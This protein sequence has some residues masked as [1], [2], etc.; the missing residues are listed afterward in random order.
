MSNKLKTE[1]INKKHYYKADDLFDIN[2][3]YFYGCRNNPRN[4]VDKKNIPEGSYLYAYT[5]ND[6]YV[7]S[8]KGYMRAKLYIDKIWAD[9][10]IKGIVS[11]PVDNI[12]DP[13]KLPLV[14]DCNGIEMA[15]PEIKL[16]DDEHFL[17]TD[18][19]KLNIKIRGN[20]DKREYYFFVN[21]ISKHFNLPNLNITLTKKDSGYEK[22]TH[23]KTFAC[24]R[25]DKETKKNNSLY[26]T[27]KG[28]IRCLYVSR[29]PNADKFQ[30]WSTNILLTHQFGSKN[31]KISL[32]SSLMG[33]PT[34]ILKNVLKSCMNPTP[35]IYMFTLGHVKDLRLSMNIDKKYN[36]DMI[37][38]KYGKTDNLERRISEHEKTYGSIKGCDLNVKY[39]SYIDP[40]NITQAE[41]NI[42]TYF[43]SMNAHIV[44]DK[45]KELIIVDKK[46][47]NDQISVQY[48][49]LVKMYAGSV[50]ELN[51]KIKQLEQQIITND[52][53]TKCGNAEL[54]AELDLLKKD[55]LIEGLEK[56]R[57]INKL[58]Y[59]KDK[60]IA[61]LKHKFEIELLKKDLEC[62]KKMKK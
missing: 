45:H 39:Y 40:L 33:I 1:L 9:T 35:C 3:A 56:D 60:E 13:K 28:L 2:P 38:C 55:K 30:D 61:E 31:E 59:E 25:N 52:A 5:K 37:V 57:E 12:I 6:E 51:A 54:R 10:N 42:R 21:D 41:N 50:T 53:I 26:L 46:T 15:P 49:I 43:K 20:R 32:A 23:Y 7:I 34:N 11:I 27:Y 44:Y 18:D 47:L 24:Q 29:S 36:D 48:E 62:A 16:N 22:N 8:S 19:N 17:D 14:E 58:I 4:I